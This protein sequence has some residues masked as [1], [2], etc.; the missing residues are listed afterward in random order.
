MKS[1]TVHNVE[2]DY[3]KILNSMINAP[4]R[5]EIPMPNNDNGKPVTLYLKSDRIES[6]EL[7]ERK[8]VENE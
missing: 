5:L 2:S 1:G 4:Q 7:I 8:E 6:I 3:Y